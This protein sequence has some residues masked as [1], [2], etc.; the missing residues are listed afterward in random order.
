MKERKRGLKLPKVLIV[1]GDI[2]YR[3]MLTHMGMELVSVRSI[4]EFKEIAPELELAMFTGGADVNPVLYGG[5]HTDISF[6]D[7]DRDRVEEVIFNLC[8]K[9]GIKIT[10]ICRGFQFLN[11]MCGGKMY[12]HINHHA[13][14]LHNVIYPATGQE[15]MVT[16]THHQLVMPP[17]DAVPVAWSEPNLSDIY[18]GPDTNSIEGPAHETESAIYPDYNTFGAQFHPEMMEEGMPG[19]TYYEKVL[20]D[21]LSLD[22]E[23][24]T[25]L[26]GYKGE[27]NGE[28]QL[29]GK[30]NQAGRRVNREG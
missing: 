1:G 7:P 11:V 17:K 20:S 4:A 24:F 6:I 19:R 12:Q 28:E 29:Q 14:P 10:G 2:L 25:Q 27:D 13:G 18:I 15:A 3:R 16:S 23:P 21:F 8:L 9:H 30:A 5:V 22:I 26:Y